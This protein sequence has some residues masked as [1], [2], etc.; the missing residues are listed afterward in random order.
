MKFKF[1][2]QFQ[3]FTIRAGSVVGAIG[4]FLKDKTPQLFN[5]NAVKETM[6]K[7]SGE[8]PGTDVKQIKGMLIFFIFF[9]L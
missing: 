2:F 3:G 7:L 1:F 4:K 9:S 5:K 8:P 6:P